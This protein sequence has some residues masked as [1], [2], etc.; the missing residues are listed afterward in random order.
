MVSS[1]L[2][3]LQGRRGERCLLSGPGR[4]DC[5]SRRGKGRVCVCEGGTLEGEDGHHRVDDVRHVASL[6]KVAS[7]GW[8]T[9]E[10]GVDGI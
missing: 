9:G 1:A 4:R 10:E 8:G 5:C 7:V 2:S 6:S 3:L